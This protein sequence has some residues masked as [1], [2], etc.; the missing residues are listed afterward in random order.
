MQP[1]QEKLKAKKAEL[2]ALSPLKNTESYKLA[3][4]DKF[5]EKLKSH[6]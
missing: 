6:R 3:E 5:R 4:L 1:K 2:E